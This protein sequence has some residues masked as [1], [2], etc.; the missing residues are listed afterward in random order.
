MSNSNKRKGT[1]WEVALVKHFNNARTFL[2][3]V[4]RA[5]DWGTAD[6]GDLVNTRDF[7]LQAKNRKAIDLAGFVD[8][9]AL[10]KRNAGKRW[11]AVLVKRRNR[12]TGSAYVVMSL[13]DWADLVKHLYELEEAKS[14]T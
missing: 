4:F 3:E 8:D 5:P 9:V 6:K 1:D 11:G 13:D 10:Q 12:S 14:Q 2:Q 7:A